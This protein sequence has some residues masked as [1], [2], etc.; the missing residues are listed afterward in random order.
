VKGW[1]KIIQANE[2]LKQSGVA[3]LIPDKIDFR[4]K[5]VRRDNEGHMILMKGTIHQEE[6]TIFNVYAP[7]VHAPNY[8]KKNCA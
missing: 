4:L 7:N 6:I 5:L 2:P 8:I 1:K 3:I